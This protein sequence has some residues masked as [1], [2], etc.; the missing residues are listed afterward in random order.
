MLLY[1]ICPVE[2][3]QARVAMER[4]LF[5]V[6][7]LVSREKVTTVGHVRTDRTVVTLLNLCNLALYVGAIRHVVVC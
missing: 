7:V 4:L 2:L 5:F 1:M 6:N 3:F